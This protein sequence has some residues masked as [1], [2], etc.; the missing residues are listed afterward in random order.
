MAFRSVIDEISFELSKLLLFNA[1]LNSVI[2]YMIVYLVLALFSFYPLFFSAISAL[3]FFIIS[4]VFFAKENSILKVESKYSAL[5]EKL[6]TAADNVNLN[7][8]VVSELQEDIVKDLQRVEDS[9]FFSE[10]RTYTKILLIML[11][12]FIIIFSAPVSFR[13]NAPDV[14]LTDMPFTFGRGGGSEVEG[15]GTGAGVGPSSGDIYGVKSVAKLGT[16]EIK[17][18]LKH[19]GFEVNLR[20]VAD[21]EQREFEENF[22]A[23]VYAES[24]EGLEESIPKDEQEIV[25]NYFKA[26]AENQG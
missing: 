18:E 1:F 17:I 26:V 21:I 20:S 25:K 3:L 8:S 11:L 22:P 13:V 12:A 16:E 10:R 14:K 6:R 2:V 24:S 23:E 4:L 5:K 9:A 15:K 7:N 19:I